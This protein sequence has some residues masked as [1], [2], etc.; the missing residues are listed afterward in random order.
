MAQNLLQTLLATM[1]DVLPI[2]VIIV[3]FQSLAIRRPIA[4]MRRVALG[5]L[6]V[7]VGLAFFY[8]G[9]RRPSFLWENSWPSN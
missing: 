8:R 1:A 6:Y 5:F 3:G 2:A 7:L 4:N 9:W